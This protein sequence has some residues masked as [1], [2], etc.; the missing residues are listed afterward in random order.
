MDVPEEL[1]KVIQ[2]LMREFHKNVAQDIN[3]MYTKAFKRGDVQELEQC[4]D[5]FLDS[6]FFWATKLQL[7]IPK[8]YDYQ[9]QLSI[10]KYFSSSFMNAICN[11]D[12]VLFIQKELETK[13]LELEA[14]LLSLDYPVGD[15]ATTKTTTSATTTPATTTK[16]SQPDDEYTDSY[17]GSDEEDY[18]EDEDEHEED[19]LLTNNNASSSSSTQSTLN[20]SSNNNNKEETDLNIENSNLDKKR[21]NII[22]RLLLS[23]NNDLFNTIMLLETRDFQKLYLNNTI[24]PQDTPSQLTKVFSEFKKISFGFDQYFPDKSVFTR[25]PLD[26]SELEHPILTTRSIKKPNLG[27]LSVISS[28]D[29][30]QKSFNVFT[31]GLFEGVSFAKD[32]CGTSVI[33]TGGSVTACLEPLSV[34]ELI[35]YRDM[36]M[37]KRTVD[38]LN[39]PWGPREK[40]NEFLDPY[41]PFY[42]LIFTKFFNTNSMYLDS[43]IDLFFVAPSLSLGQARL[44]ETA[45]QIEK[46]LRHKVGNEFRFVRTAN[47][48]SI[49]SKFPYRPIQLVVFIIRSIEDLILFYDLDCVTNA[50]DG[51]NVYLLP[52]AVNSFNKRV[53]YIGPKLWK[54]SNKRM[55]KYVFR[56][57]DAVCFEFCIHANRCDKTKDLF[58]F[59]QRRSPDRVYSQ[60]NRK[61]LFKKDGNGEY[62]G[63]LFPFAP[64]NS[65]KKVEKYFKLTTDTCVPT[66]TFDSELFFKTLPKE[67]FFYKQLNWKFYNIRM[68]QLVTNIKLK[69]Y[70]CQAPLTYNNETRICLDCQNKTS[71]LATRW[72]EYFR[73]YAQFI[74]EKVAIVT[75][76][77]IKIGYMTAKNLLMAGFK[78]VV[79]SRFPMVTCEK[80]KADPEL[81]E[82][83]LK[84]LFVYGLDFRNLSAV[85]EFINYIKANFTRVDVLI[86]NAAQTIRRPRAYY[87]EILVQEEKLLSIKDGETTETKTSDQDENNNN[88][89]QDENN[90]LVKISVE[91]NSHLSTFLVKQKILPDQDEEEV[92]HH[93]FPVGQV[94]EHGEQLDL[95]S[96][97]SWISTISEI[98]PVEIFEVNL[99]NSTVP[100]MLISS[101]MP[102]MGTNSKPVKTPPADFSNYLKP[103]TRF[104]WSYIINVTSPEGNINHELN[105]LSGYHAHT[106]MAKAALNMLTKTIAY[107]AERQNIYVCGVD[108]GWISNMRPSNSKSQTRPPPLSESDGALRI[109]YPIY[110]N[111]FENSTPSGVQYVNFIST[112][113]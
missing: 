97:T 16:K 32:S 4:F 89:N 78:V 83:M 48:I 62:D 30:F 110:K 53:N 92:N 41:F 94:D 19:S 31:Q 8:D 40:I 54:E 11:K 85:Q 33:A 57:F 10:W 96:H 69:C 34:T 82:S 87:N 42:N 35:A 2:D 60:R 108:T 111:L 63:L 12:I 49:V 5:R 15:E 27:D 72:N 77:R 29:L 104:D 7:L 43:D 88:N 25:I 101:L 51:Q 20:T 75:G 13:K 26:P 86:N 91:R 109:V 68:T 61:K 95:R 100:A 9:I 6:A 99:V 14:I 65:W 76:G 44:E 52:R 103:N 70:C 37:I 24:L 102:M 74:Q 46:N 84:N 23:I 80:F 18:E 17:D 28:L 1:S 64:N 93:L 81:N 45:K 66:A 50:Y 107:G 67:K 56:G 90:K 98:S 112:P 79:T 21:L 47:S 36:M 38:K 113:W 105:G 22:N 106:N 71:L 58:D 3:A 73:V 55:Y 39:L 59:C